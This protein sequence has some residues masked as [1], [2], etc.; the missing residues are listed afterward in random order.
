[1]W[2]R[3][4]PAAAPETAAA[5]AA[6]AAASASPHVS[7]PSRPATPITA[8]E[9]AWPKRRDFSQPGAPAVVTPPKAPLPLILPDEPPAPFSHRWARGTA[10]FG[11]MGLW[12]GACSGYWRGQNVT[13]AA[14]NMGTNWTL[15]GGLFLVLREGTL[16][17]CRAIN[18]RRGDSS[19]LMRHKDAAIAAVVAGGLTGGLM[20]LLRRGP[21]AVPA[22][23]L[24]Y[25]SAGAVVQ[26]GLNAVE[27]WRMHEALRRYL[28]ATGVAPTPAPAPAAPWY[29]MDMAPAGT[30]A[31]APVTKRDPFGTAW[32]AFWE[33]VQA[34]SSASASDW[35]RPVLFAF[36]M[37]YRERLDTRIRLLREHNAL[38]QARLDGLPADPGLTESPA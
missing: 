3:A 2:F 33:A 8:A 15:A 22:G 16:H 11:A 30:D 20:G 13:A 27:L 12:I 4:Q 23:I 29:A 35:L 6:A 32:T 19:L 34:R 17:G 25:A 9:S 24:I 7:P 31:G 38:M 18:D 21:I 26:S 1:M 37:E 28:V 5:A 36:D 14:F 10:R